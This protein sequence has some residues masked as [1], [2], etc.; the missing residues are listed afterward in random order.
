M[1]M[2]IGWSGNGGEIK[3]MR[4]ERKKRK[5]TGKERDEGV[6]VIRFFVFFFTI[7]RCFRVFFGR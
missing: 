3:K 1:G 7:K 6:V 2:G 4:W 5:K